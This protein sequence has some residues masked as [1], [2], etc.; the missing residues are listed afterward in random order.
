MRYNQIIVTQKRPQIADLDILPQIDRGLVDYKKYHKH[1]G[2]SGIKNCFTI[3]GSRGCPYRCVYCD[4]IKLTPRLYRRSAENLFNEIEYLYKIGARHIEFIDDIFNVNKKE[5]IAFFRMIKARKVDMSF[6][7][8]SGLRGD[9]LDAEAIDT[10]MEGG[11]KSVNISLESASP[12]LQK[13]MKKN[14]NIDKFQRNLQYIVANYPK[15]I[16]GLNAMHGF[17]TETEEEA[18]A[19]LQFIKD[20]KWLHF[21]QLHNVRIFPGS[22]IEEIAL[23]N[24]VTR[25]QINESLTM[26]YNMIPTTSPFNHEFSRKLRLD[27]VHSYVLNKE[28]LRTVLQNQL[29]ICTEEEILFKYQSYFPSQINSIDDILR[30]ARLKRSDFDFTKQPKEVGTN[31]DYPTSPKT[32][33]KTRKQENR[34]LRILYIDATQ[35]FSA[36]ERSEL[37]IVE[38]PLGLLALLSYMNEK[39][40]DRIDGKIIK[41][42]IDYDS[43]EELTK[44]IADF[45]PDL[46]GIR[47]LSYY[48]NFFKDTVA[49]IRLN[50]TKVPIIAGGPHPTIAY[51]DV[52]EENDIQVI[53]IGE[54]EIT[55]AEIITAMLN[56]DE[57]K[58]PSNE[59]L[60]GI[61]GI[62]YKGDV[63][64]R[65]N[66][67]ALQSIS[68][69]SI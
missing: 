54:G 38:P 23:S 9:I 62:V 58:F 46:I 11:V 63:F 51:N 14:L 48:K 32:K 2:Q 37:R 21:A 66:T 56:S 19:T 27:F 3:Q 65:T 53:V 13:L 30:L 57:Y 55:N 20:V 49:Q 15:A 8:Q 34:P 26:P 44:I 25:E 69:K 40:Q 50:D 36:D 64:P 28:R 22:V 5:F 7:F 29:E 43:F 35:F 17:P 52:L 18:L 24:G 59:V 68:I 60:N 45:K 33:N 6:Y 39:F 31:I 12:R 67:T 41:S 10:M 47:T 61:H 4:V 16:L 1:I 42:L